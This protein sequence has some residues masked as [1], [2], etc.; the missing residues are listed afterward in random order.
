[1]DTPLPVPVQEFNLLSSLNWRAQI[2][3]CPNAAFLMQKVTIPSIT[4]PPAGEPTPFTV[5]PQPGDH[6]QFDYLSL[7][8]KVDEDLTNYL[9]IFNW[10]TAL[11]FPE[12]FVQYAKVQNNLKSPVRVTSLSGKKNPRVE[13]IFNDAFPVYLGSLDFTYTD[14][15]VQYVPCNVI[16]AYTNFNVARVPGV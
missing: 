11:G 4:L 12:N 1:M 3:R 9:E 10:I 16:L 6:I 15:D 5:I 7:Q 2:D 8:F 13:F 14:N